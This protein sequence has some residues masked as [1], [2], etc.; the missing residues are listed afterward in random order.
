MVAMGDI[1]MANDDMTY[2]ALAEKRIV[3]EDYFSDEDRLLNDVALVRLETAPTGPGIGIIELAPENMD[4]LEDKIVRTSGWG[5]VSNTGEG[6]DY[7]L[8]ALMRVISNEECQKAF[9]SNPAWVQP[10]TICTTWY[11][12]QGQA[13]CDG[14]S[15]GPLV[16]HV[17]GRDV[18]IGVAS[19]GKTACDEGPS[20]HARVSSFRDWIDSTIALN[21]D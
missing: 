3:H 9:V 15:G 11:T 21:S 1:N 2:V 5:K 19:F 20:G 4:S 7:L 13:I 12:Q 6:S 8:K 10:T 18:L 16:H 17:D 14:D